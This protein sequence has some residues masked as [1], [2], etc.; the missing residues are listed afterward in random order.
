MLLSIL[1]FHRR[2][3]LGSALR[4]VLAVLMFFVPGLILM[5]GPASLA[6]ITV[7]DRLWETLLRVL[8]LFALSRKWIWTHGSAVEI[9]LTLLLLFC[10]GWAWFLL[11]T[12]Q[13]AARHQS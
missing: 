1:R 4:G 7:Y 3:R 5:G 12:G 9:L 8:I 2:M 10:A 6:E 13:R 11:G